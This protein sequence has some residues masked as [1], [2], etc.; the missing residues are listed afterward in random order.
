M[1]L[2]NVKIS[3]ANGAMG[4]ID[5]TGDGIS[6]LVLNSSAAA[7]GLALATPAVIYNLQAAI[8]LGITQTALPEV[9][10][11]IKEF[12][13]GYNY[14]TGSQNAE[15]YIMLV[16]QT[17]TLAQMA[18]TTVANSASK[19]VDYA[20]GRV[21][22]LALARNPASGYTPVLTNG[23]D[24]DVL[25]ALP[26][27]QLLGNTYAERQWPLRVLIEGRGFAL[28]NIGPLKDLRTY[29]NNRAGVVMAS[30]ANDGSASVGFALGVAAGLP[31]HRS[32]ARVKNGALTPIVIGYNGD[33]QADAMPGAI[34][35][36]HDKG[37]IIFRTFPNRAGY[38]FNDDPMAASKTDDYSQLVYG[39]VIDKA[40]RVVYNVLVDEVN[41]DVDV[42]AGGKLHPA[43]IATI[44]SNITRAA[45]VSLADNV[46]KNEDG[47]LAF[48]AYIDPDQNVISTE[49]LQVT[50]RARPKGYNKTIEVSLGYSLS[51]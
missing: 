14:V 46:S 7:S 21:K 5:E 41:D 1:P 12:Y 2:P 48:T 42:L 40:Q 45:A 15:L 11:H 9:Y 3:L 36:I 37:Y 38:F 8:A 50:V 22:R 20:N 27:A 49:K 44:E 26:K 47:S 30:S 28:A 51:I 34:D 19:L 43:V 18:D 33:T 17:M 10:R 13:D 35:T 32:I 24:A 31:A 4:R 29:A 16:A 39:S 25:A 23:I 6:G